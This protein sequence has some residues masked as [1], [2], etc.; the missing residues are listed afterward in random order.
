MI[1][2]NESTSP[3]NAHHAGER[4]AADAPLRRRRPQI[5]NSRHHTRG[6]AL[7]Q[8]ARCMAKSTRVSA[9]ERQSVKSFPSSV[10]LSTAAMTP[11]APLSISTPA[12]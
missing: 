11:E 1:S 5:A 2:R 9:G 12:A 8:R 6:A 3:L 10:K 4:R 7:D